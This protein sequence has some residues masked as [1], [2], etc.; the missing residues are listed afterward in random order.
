MREVDN[1]NRTNQTGLGTPSG[2]G[3]WTAG[4]NGPGGFANVS[5]D[6][7]SNQAKAV[8]DY[9]SAYHSQDIV[10]YGYVACAHGGPDLVELEW[11]T[12]NAGGTWSG[13]SFGWNAFDGVWSI[14]R[15][16]GDVLLVT[17]TTAFPGSL[18]L[19]RM[20]VTDTSVIGE[21]STDSGVT[22]INLGS[23]NDTT[24]RSTTTKVGFLVSP[25][26]IVDSFYLSD[27]F[28]FKAITLG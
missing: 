13:Y 28:F 1:F 19:L 24:N 11:M 26:T 25:N 16:S 8:G 14:Y 9:R 5:L 18:P 4:V 3:S 20:R 6:I 27:P 10:S 23:S 2:Y 21:Y 12:A 22:W 15:Q 17:G 7:V